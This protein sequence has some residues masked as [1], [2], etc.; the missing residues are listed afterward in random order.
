MI[1][2]DKGQKER[3][4]VCAVEKWNPHPSGLWFRNGHHYRLTVE[5]GTVENW[6]DC[7]LPPTGPAGNMP[8]RLR[9]VA[10]LRRYDGAP[11]FALVG[12]VGRKHP[13]LIGWEKPDYRPPADG[14]FM[15][16]ANDFYLAYW[17]NKGSLTLCIERLE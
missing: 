15:C 14:D 5:Q 11:W 13:F 2:L 12:T 8:T 7:G 1:E 17:N 4:K 9:L 6:K 16:Y 10:W 3:M